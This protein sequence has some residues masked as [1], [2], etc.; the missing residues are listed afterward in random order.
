MLTIRAA[1]A[2]D[3]DAIWAILEPII[4]AGETYPLP[5]DLSR[6]DGLAYWHSPGHEV[7]VAEDNNAILGAYF[8]KANQRGGGTHVANCGYMT[9]PAA[10]GRGVAS[11]MCTHS[12]DHARA[13]GF[14][15]MQ[16]NFVV[17]VNEVAVNLWKSL[18]FEII[19]ALPKGYQHAGKGL[20][21][22][23]IMHRFL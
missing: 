13:R 10:T 14:T 11:A 20:V 21:D 8:L 17:S 15:A 18:G 12:L 9:A 6:D 1:V 16:F 23:Y 2:T 3:R 4:R 7:F 22:V 19:G 5:R